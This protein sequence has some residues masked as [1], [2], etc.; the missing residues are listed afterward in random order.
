MNRKTLI[1]VMLTFLTFNLFGQI[2]P[3]EKKP[4][5]IG[6]SLGYGGVGFPFFPSADFSVKSTS[7]RISPGYQ[8]LSGG[9]AQEL[10]GLSEIYHQWKWV[11]SAYFSKSRPN[12]MWPGGIGVNG[13]G[14]NVNRMMML[15]GVKTYLGTRMYT[16]LQLGAMYS[17]FFRRETLILGVTPMVIE[18]YTEWTPYI[19]F[20]FGVNFFRNYRQVLDNIEE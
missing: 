14:E 19:E 15:T 11:A 2:T 1:V 18:P 17:S 10:F 13:V 3:P 7:L 9:V 6:L 8:S 20:S 5:N 4:Y 12:G 16:Y